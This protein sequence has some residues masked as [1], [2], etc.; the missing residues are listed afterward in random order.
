MVAHHSLQ[1]RINEAWNS[2]SWAEIEG[3]RMHYQKAGSGPPLLLIHGLLGGSFSWRFNVADLGARRTTY[4]LDLPGQGISDAPSRTDC[5]MRAQAR[6]ISRF[7]D[8][9]EL[10]EVDVVASSWGGAI[11]LL[12][13][14]YDARVR[15]LV[16]AAPV[17]PWSVFGRDRVR[18]FSSRLGALTIRFGLPFSGPLQRTSVEQ[19]YGDPA[20]IRPGTMEGYC[21]LLRRRGRAANLI[22]IMRCWEH[23]LT[24]LADAIPRMQVPTLL[25]WGS[26]DGAVD[27]ASAELLR[28]SLPSCRLEVLPGIGHLPFEE[29]P[30]VFNR[31]VLDFIE[32]GG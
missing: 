21:A 15:S 14:A 20:R 3:Q 16:L 25:I 12:L 18:F 26:R 22:N 6:R 27:P 19:M 23:D 7:M 31:L 17:N 13:A 1:A 10:S 9:N 30:E 8:A 5:G 29:C 2:S 32:R 11:A 24:A 4:V 28:R